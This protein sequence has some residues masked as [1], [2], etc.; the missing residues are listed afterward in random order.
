MKAALLNYHA[1]MQRVLTPLS[2]VIG[3][4]LTIGKRHHDQSRKDHRAF[5][6]ESL[7]LPVLTSG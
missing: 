1:R 5:G 7:G 2:W 6:F 4:A 3:C